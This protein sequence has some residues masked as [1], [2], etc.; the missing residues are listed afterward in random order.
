MP[1]LHT[2]TFGDEMNRLPCECFP[3]KYSAGDSRDQLDAR[4]T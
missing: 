2:E 4:S 3:Q 1:L